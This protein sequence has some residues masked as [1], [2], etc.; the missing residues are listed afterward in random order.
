M[1]NR[2]WN[3]K[4]KANPLSGARLSS[5]ECR[6]CRGQIS[7]SPVPPAPRLLCLVSDE[8]WRP[9]VHHRLRAEFHSPAPNILQT[10]ANALASSLGLPS[11]GY[12]ASETP[13]WN[14]GK[15]LRICSLRPVH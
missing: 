7:L 3:L 1:E 2:N 5:Q 6:L 10:G 4:Q 14:Q 12:E 13:R 8:V 11:D 15:I 9:W